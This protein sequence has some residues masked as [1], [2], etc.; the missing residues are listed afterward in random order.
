MGLAMTPEVGKV[1]V[2]VYEIREELQK[3]G[4]WSDEACPPLAPKAMYLGLPY[5]K[6][7]QYAYLP[8]VERF[9]WDGA[10][11]QVPPVRIGIAA[12]RH[13]DYFS[14]LEGSGPLIYAC[15]R[16][17]DLLQKVPGVFAETLW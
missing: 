17:D 5:E 4:L 11:G 8:A 2:K 12:L 1:L 7:L 13:Y 16:L 15:G 6:W 3:L 10:M 9:V 14:Y